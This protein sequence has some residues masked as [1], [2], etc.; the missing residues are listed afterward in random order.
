MNNM[1]HAYS[2]VCALWCLMKVSQ[3]ART[4]TINN[5]KF[6]SFSDFVHS[7]GNGVYMRINAR[8]LNYSESTTSD[9]DGSLD[10]LI[11][12]DRT[13]CSRRRT[14]ALYTGCSMQIVKWYKYRAGLSGDINVPSSLV[15]VGPYFPFRRVAFIRFRGKNIAFLYPAV[16][17]TYL[18]SSSPTR[19]SFSVAIS[20]YCS[21]LY[22]SYTVEYV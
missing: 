9:A 8:L 13:E 14:S 10:F 19:Y 4:Y 18:H 21:C 16:I 11:T 12:S 5:L 2:N 3:S 6:Y 17:Y 1:Q 20:C 15:P 22:I 7:Y